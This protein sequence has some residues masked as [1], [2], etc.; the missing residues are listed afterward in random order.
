MK[1]PTSYKA[2]I[3]TLLVLIAII[4][5]QLALA[6]ISQVHT[7]CG[8]WTVITYPGSFYVDGFDPFGWYHHGHIKSNG[9]VSFLARNRA[10]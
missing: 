5:P 8:V 10:L 2:A 3:A 9:E 6:G 4:C 7:R 1:I